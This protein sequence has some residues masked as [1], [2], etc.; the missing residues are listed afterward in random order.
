MRCSI[1]LLLLLLC[2]SGQ[3]IQTYDKKWTARLENT[4][5]E[6]PDAIVKTP[7]IAHHGTVYVSAGNAVFAI[8]A[9][10]CELSGHCRVTPLYKFPIPLLTSPAVSSNGIYLYVTYV[11]PLGHSI[12]GSEKY[13]AIFAIFDLRR[14]NLTDPIWSHPEDKALFSAPTVD[15]LGNIYVKI[16]YDYKHSMQVGLLKIS[17]GVI[18][19]AVVTTVNFTSVYVR[20]TAEQN[21]LGLPVYNG[22]GVAAGGAAIAEIDE[23]LYNILFHSGHYLFYTSFEKTLLPQHNWLNYYNYDG[24]GSPLEQVNYSVPTIANNP[25]NLASYGEISVAN[26]HGD[27][28][29]YQ[30]APFM[31][32]K[33]GADNY[34]VPRKWRRNLTNNSLADSTPVAAD[35]GTVYIGNSVTG[36][37]YA[38]NYVHDKEGP[39]REIK[40]STSGITKPPA[41]D[42]NNGVV[43]V[44]D[45]SGGLYAVDA[46]RLERLWSDENAHAITAPVVGLDG[47]VVIGTKGNTVIAYQGG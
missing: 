41:V 28:E 38:F 12:I 5:S 10:R 37:L 7:V 15:I 23:S 31:S 42:N 22:E 46:H 36:I 43:Y 45:D 39:K 13:Q 14:P 19:P 20:H 26:G 34:K 30:K 32:I 40:L 1:S 27:L 25:A 4:T 33:G 24:W 35:D 9:R 44:V 8:P 2:A 17:G 16:I 3:A 11:Q 29:A 6:D 21:E 18:P 47:T